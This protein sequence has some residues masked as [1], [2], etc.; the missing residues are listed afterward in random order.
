MSEL[1]LIISF[2]RSH[3][4]PQELGRIT[5]LAT[6]VF[7]IAIL[8]N[9]LTKLGA[10]LEYYEPGAMVKSYLYQHS[11]SLGRDK[12]KLHFRNP[13]EK[14]SR[15]KGDSRSTKRK[16]PNPKIEGRDNKAK[17]LKVNS[18]KVSPRDQCKRKA[19]RDKGTHVTHTH[20]D[21]RYKSNDRPQKSASDDKRHDRPLQSNLGQAPPKKARNQSQ[22][23]LARV[24][25]L[26]PMLHC[27]KLSR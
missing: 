5:T 21:C 15:H 14:D 11:H 9:L 13:K 12:D 7:D 23:C 10:S 2:R 8:T 3:F 17:R 20:K 19:C 22:P 26:R 6:G 24:L 1:H 4:T 16:P 27:P 18:Q 25:R